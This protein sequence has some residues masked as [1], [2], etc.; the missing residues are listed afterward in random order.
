MICLRNLIPAELGYG[1]DFLCT[2]GDQSVLP[3]VVQPDKFVTEA[4]EI[5]GEKFT[6][7]I[8]KKNYARREWQAGIAK[9]EYSVP[10]T[11]EQEKLQNQ[12]L[13]DY[14]RDFFFVLYHADVFIRRDVFDIRRND[15]GN[16]ARSGE[17]VKSQRNLMRVTFYAG[18]FSAKKITVNQNFWHNR[19]L[20]DISD[21]YNQFQVGQ[22]LL[23]RAR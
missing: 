10:S 12:M 21:F 5:F 22:P 2:F 16:L 7:N 1:N 6:V 14:L 3:A 9:I 18:Q 19:S 17:L 23:L 15:D 4:G 8:V 13:P 20:I 11:G